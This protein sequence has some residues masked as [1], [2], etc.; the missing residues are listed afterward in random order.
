MHGQDK[1]DGKSGWLNNGVPNTIYPL[2]T[3]ELAPYSIEAKTRDSTAYRA[4]A[5]GGGAPALI[6]MDGR[7][8]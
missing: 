4:S 2:A 3:G 1:G 7:G 6:A 5:L 8:S